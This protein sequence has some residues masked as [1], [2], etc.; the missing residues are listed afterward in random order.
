MT[1]RIFSTHD[2]AVRNGSFVR[3]SSF[4]I[5]GKICRALATYMNGDFVFNAEIP[6]AKP[7]HEAAIAELLA[8]GHRE[9]TP[10]EF[11]K[12]APKCVGG[13]S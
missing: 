1:P 3:A 13:T 9:Y 12:L 4:R 6:D 5:G 8:A 10:K 7:C 2:D 11:R